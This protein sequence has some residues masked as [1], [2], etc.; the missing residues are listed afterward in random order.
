MYIVGAHLIAA[1]A[2]MSYPEFALSRIFEPLGMASTTFSPDVAQRSGK[3]TQ[4]WTKFGRRISFWFTEEIAHLKA[5]PG[6]IISSAND[7][8]R[9]IAHFACTQTIK[10]LTEN[11]QTKW[12]TVLLNAGVEPVSNTTIIPRSVFDEMTTAHSVVYGS[13]PAPDSSLIGYGM[14]WDRWSYRGH[15]VT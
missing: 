9:R 5:G 13:S 10:I 2:N 11:G 8:V 3:R 7:L 14:G 6:G 15:E 12:V 1:Y 4:T